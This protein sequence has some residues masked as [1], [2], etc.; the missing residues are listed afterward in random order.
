[1]N[2]NALTQAAPA[3]RPA[4]GKGQAGRDADRKAWQQ[5][6]EHALHGLAPSGPQTTPPKGS[7][8]ARPNAQGAAEK[9]LAHPG[10]PA[11]RDR[12]DKPHAP[13]APASIMV[14][15]PTSAP[16]SSPGA[17]QSAARPGEDKAAAREPAL[18]LQANDNAGPQ[19]AGRSAATGLVD[20]AEGSRSRAAPQP[21]ARTF[22][23]APNPIA[24]A[25]AGERAPA[26]QALSDAANAIAA[27]AASQPQ[28]PRPTAHAITTAVHVPQPASS[29]QRELAGAALAI[30]ASAPEKEKVTDSSALVAGIAGAGSAQGPGVAPQTPPATSAPVVQSAPHAMVAP[31]VNTQ[32][33][34]AA[35]SALFQNGGGSATVQLTPPALGYVEIRIQ[36]RADHSASVSFVVSQPAAAQAI[37]AGLP[38]L[39]QALQQNHIVLAHTDVSGGTASWQ[40]PSHGGQQGHGQGQHEGSLVGYGR[41]DGHK[42]SGDATGVRAY[43]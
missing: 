33:L 12:H 35:A 13:T 4:A 14:A 29:M 3:S 31:D 11:R 2:V 42:A 20:R 36:V 16:T 37:Q 39:S 40:G 23:S 1:M 34:G 7:D 5:A 22:A 27:T 24:K 25:V 28:P 43:A 9:T 6:D 19:G 8:N 18:P 30:P 17:G 32:A 38:A 41:R 10:K 21:P 26:A 15:L